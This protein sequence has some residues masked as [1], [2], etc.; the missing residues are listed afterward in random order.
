M[1]YRSDRHAPRDGL[2]I[3]G[4]NGVRIKKAAAVIK[5]ELPRRRQVQKRMIDLCRGSLPTVTDSVSVLRHRSHIKQRNGHSR[6]VRKIVATGTT[7]P[8]EL[9]FYKI[10]IR[11]IRIAF[12]ACRTPAQYPGIRYRVHGYRDRNFWRYSA[13]RKGAWHASCFLQLPHAGT[14]R[15]ENTGISK[16]VTAFT[17]RDTISPFNWYSRSTS[18]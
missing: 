14:R 2:V 16:P 5:F 15:L 8:A 7:T 9:V 12:L 18:Y 3:L 17:P 10:L 6:L 4:W 11:K 13:S 1:T